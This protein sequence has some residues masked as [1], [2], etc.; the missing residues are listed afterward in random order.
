MGQT[1]QANAMNAAYTENAANSIVAFQNDVE[2]VQLDRMAGQEDSALAKMQ[3]QREGIVARAAAKA[4]YGSRG[5]G[6][7]S[8][9]A[10]HRALGFQTGERVAYADRNDQLDDERARLGLRNARDTARSR[11]NSA[12]TAAKPNLLALGASL[13]GSAV[14]SYGM[15]SGLKADERATNLYVK[16]AQA[17]IERP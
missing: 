17:Q 1:Q 7:L 14:N 9:D 16:Q 12:P 10:I 5:I 15:Y 11:I 3:A 8:A 13:V 6:G 2:A 4:D